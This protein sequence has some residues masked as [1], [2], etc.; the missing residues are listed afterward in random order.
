M[1]QDRK[2][3]TTQVPPRQESKTETAGERES[4]PDGWS[5]WKDWDLP[6]S[7]RDWEPE[8]ER[9]PPERRR[10]SSHSRERRNPS[11]R[12]ARSP[13]RQESAPSP[14]QSIA[15]KR[16]HFRRRW[17]RIVRENN[18][19]RYAFNEGR[20]KIR[21]NQGHSIS[22]DVELKAAE[23]PKYLYHGTASRFLPAI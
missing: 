16:L 13:E 23:P 5:P 22:V 11:S 12:K 21:A 1:S 14:R 8:G 10:A 6:P 2:K 15:Q 7:I 18:K 9:R 17:R 3:T 4:F 19:Q 20:T